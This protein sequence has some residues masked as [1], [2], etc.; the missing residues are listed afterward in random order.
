MPEL[1]DLV[2]CGAWVAESMMA[3]MSMITDM[4]TSAHGEG[5]LKLTLTIW[6]VRTPSN[7]STNTYYVQCR[8]DRRRHEW[9][10]LSSNSSRQL[11]NVTTR[12][13]NYSNKNANRIQTPTSPHVTVDTLRLTPV[14]RVVQSDLVRSAHQ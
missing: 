9:T 10:Y 3:A 1:V 2:L 14:V 7:S 13:A 12:D 4:H 8:H 6:K 11:K 5:R